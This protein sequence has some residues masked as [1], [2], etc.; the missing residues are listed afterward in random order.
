MLLSLRRELPETPTKHPG[1]EEEEKTCNE[2]G[3]KDIG[4][5]EEAEDRGGGEHRHRQEGW[6]SQQVLGRWFLCFKIDLSSY[7]QILRNLNLR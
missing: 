1:A 5:G 3:D 4:T 7:Q 2:S 6:R